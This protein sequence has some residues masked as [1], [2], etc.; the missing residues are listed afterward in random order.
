MLRISK[1]TDYGIVIATHLASCDKPHPVSDLSAETQIPAPTVAK[2]LKALAKAE[3]AMRA[4]EAKIDLTCQVG[5]V[6]QGI[7]G[8]FTLVGVNTYVIPNGGAGSPLW[9]TKTADEILADL[10]G[11]GHRASVAGRDLPFDLGCGGIDE[12]D[13]SHAATRIHSERGVQPGWS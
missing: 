3:A 5:D 12:S 9:S 10:Q 6:P 8:L 7:R 13:S 1:L 4:I 11:F 2:V